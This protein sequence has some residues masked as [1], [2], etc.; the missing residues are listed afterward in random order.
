MTTILLTLD[1][2]E[3]REYVFRPG[4]MLKGNFELKFEIILRIGYKVEILIF[5]LGTVMLS[6]SN[7]RKFRGTIIF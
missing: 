1:P 5:S 7:A 3:S 4:Q 6:L 2:D